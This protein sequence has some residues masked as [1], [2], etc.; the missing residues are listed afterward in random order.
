MKNLLLIALTIF[1]FTSCKQD[2]SKKQ[3]LMGK[4]QGVSWNISGKASDRDAKSVHFEFANTDT[5]SASWGGQSEKGSF[6]LSGDKLYTTAEATNK[7]EKMVK[8]STLTADTIVM[9]M[10]RMGDSE[11]L[12]LVKK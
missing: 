8:L 1:I 6:R 9:D 12:V 4:W 11:Q 3:L 5:Y 7:I 10:N 2:D